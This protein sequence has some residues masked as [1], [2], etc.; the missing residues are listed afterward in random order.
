MP[1]VE[2]L[3]TQMIDIHADTREIL[4]H[5]KQQAA[6]RSLS[7][8]FVV[9]VDSHH[10]PESDWV[11]ITKYLRDPV[12]RHNIVQQSQLRGGNAYG[13]GTTGYGFQDMFGRIPH[14]SKLGERI[15]D[16]SVYKDVVLFRRAMD[17]LGIDVQVV[18]PTG[19]LGL[20]MNYVGDAEVEIAYAYNRWFVE[21]VLPHEPRVRFLPYLPL[22]S[23]EACLS[24]IEEFGATP[25]VVGFLVTSIRYDAVHSNNFMPIY[26]LLEDVGKPLAFHAGPTWEDQWMKTMNKFISMHAI[27]FVHCNMVHLTNWVMNGLPERFPKLKVMWL[28]SGLAWIPFMMQRLDSEY[29]KRSSEAPLLKR[30]PSQYIQDMYFT[31]QPMETTDL[32]LLE[33]TFRAI[34]ADSQLLYASDWPHWDFDLPSS[35]F[36]LP[37]VDDTAKRNILGETARGLFAL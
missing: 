13:G 32:D 28:E 5:A 12:M 9:D 6:S 35:I 24:F 2:T 22:S 19:L 14:Q 25:G 10:S 37:F 20:G 1:N 31:S 33:A 30:L 17:S 23:P 3:P 4:A 36:D 8:Y 16:P 18:F 29:L 34:H 11:E 7:D 15:D 26:S 27:S 21:T